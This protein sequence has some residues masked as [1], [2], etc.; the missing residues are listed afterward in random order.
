[1][2][3]YYMLSVRGGKVGQPDKWHN[4][5]PTECFERAKI[6]ARNIRSTGHPVKIKWCK[7]SIK[8]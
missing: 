6:D 1:M 5:M 8:K 7:G 4:L 3:H 2:A